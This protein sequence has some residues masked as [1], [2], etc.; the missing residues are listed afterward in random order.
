MNSKSIICV[1]LSTEWTETIK[2]S[3]EKMAR[4]TPMMVNVEVITAI[5]LNRKERSRYV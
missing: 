1:S 5:S 2:A 3:K 4:S